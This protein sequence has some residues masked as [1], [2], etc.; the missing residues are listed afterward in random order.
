MNVKNRVAG[1]KSFR[2]TALLMLATISAPIGAQDVLKIDVARWNAAK[3]KLILKGRSDTLHLVYVSD[4]IT[5]AAVAQTQADDDGR[6]AVKVKKPASVP[7][8]VSVT[9][10]GRTI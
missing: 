10:G 3:Q 5:M 6:W 2:L 7:C 4:E 1:G 8:A 9:S